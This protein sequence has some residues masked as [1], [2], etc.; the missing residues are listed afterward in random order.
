MERAM[1][2]NS[3]FSALALA[4]VGTAQ[5]GMLTTADF[6]CAASGLG[7][8]SGLGA[9]NMKLTLTYDAAGS[10]LNAASAITGWS[11]TISRQ[12]DGEVVFAATGTPAI[13]QN[14]AVYTRAT[15]GGVS[16]RKYTVV[17]GGGTGGWQGSAVGTGLVPVNLVE[18][19][20]TAAKSGSTYGTLGDSLT[21]SQ[22]AAGGFLFISG[23]N[24]TAGSFGAISG[25]GYA[26][27]AP[28]ALALVGAAG[29]VSSR[30]RRS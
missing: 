14:S 8:F 28:S 17:L 19:G 12:L 30:R 27:P 2:R 13:G 1:N 23:G 9:L 26:V 29:F 16:T 25:I 20:F 7:S 22:G 15:V 24:A 3:I 6:T 5:A 10:V 4:V 11:Y 21:Q 18:I